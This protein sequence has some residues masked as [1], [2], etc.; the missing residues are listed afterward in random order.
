MKHILPTLFFAILLITACKKEENPQLLANAWTGLREAY[1]SMQV[2]YGNSYYGRV[3]GRSVW[4]AGQTQITGLRWHTQE[5]TTLNIPSGAYISNLWDPEAPFI[6]IEEKKVHVFDAEQMVWNLVY[7]A[8]DGYSI[9]G[10]L[11]RH[12]ANLAILLKDNSDLRVKRV[13]IVRLPDNSVTE[14]A[15]LNQYIADNDVAIGGQPR[16]VEQGGEQY[17]LFMTM[18]YFSLNPGKF[19]AFNLSKGEVRSTLD[20]PE[21]FMDDIRLIDGSYAI[22]Y[23]KNSPTTDYIYIIDVWQNKLMHEERAATWLTYRDYLLYNRLEVNKRVDPATGN[24]V[25]SLP[26]SIK[27]GSM[28]GILDGNF[29]FFAQRVNDEGTNLYRQ[30]A[31]IDVATGAENLQYKDINNTFSGYK[32]FSRVLTYA[33]DTLL[34]AI[35]AD[36]RAHFLRPY[37]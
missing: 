23:S 31:F 2:P 30:I 8:P 25:Y 35:T 13:H 19:V 21:G 14:S 22:V 3:L 18:P 16:W 32:D 36:E 10:G 29:C 9:T 34:I 28:G 1:P 4:Y 6:A 15:A 37:K 20:L 33:P 17:L 7:E 11:P 26:E 27:V 24:S 12:E 5:I